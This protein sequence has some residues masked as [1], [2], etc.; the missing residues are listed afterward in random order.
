MA[1]QLPRQS[2]RV[3]WRIPEVERDDDRAGM[4]A[5]TV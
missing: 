1:E 5:E 3:D 4:A 2:A